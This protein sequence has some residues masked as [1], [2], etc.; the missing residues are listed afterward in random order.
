M[1]VHAMHISLAHGRERNWLFR[2]NWNQH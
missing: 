2:T 1:V